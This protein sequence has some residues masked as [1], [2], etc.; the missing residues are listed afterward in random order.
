MHEAGFRYVFLGIENILEDD[1]QFLRASS[2]TQRVKTVAKLV[3]QRSRQLITST[4]T[5]CTLLVV[6]SLVIRMILGS[7]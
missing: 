2:K 7:Q 1:L 6:S 4:K 5:R 3:T